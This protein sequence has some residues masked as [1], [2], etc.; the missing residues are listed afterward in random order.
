MIF[1]GYVILFE[2]P[3]VCL[4]GDAACPEAQTRFATMLGPLWSVWPHWGKSITLSP[5]P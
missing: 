5:G 3:Y 4:V 2:V 1:I